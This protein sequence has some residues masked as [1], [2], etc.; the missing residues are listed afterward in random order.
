MPKMP[1]HYDR[2]AA[3]PGIEGIW[4]LHKTLLDPDHNTSEELIANLEES[5]DC[6]GNWIR[7]AVSSDGVLT[8]TNGR[9]GVTKTYRVR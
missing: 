9:N 6:K 1:G 4:Q 8:M 2:I 3:S 5:A 7:A